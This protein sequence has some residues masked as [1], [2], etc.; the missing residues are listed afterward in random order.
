VHVEHQELVTGVLFLDADGE[1]VGEAVY[2][3]AWT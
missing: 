2:G 3:P 1:L